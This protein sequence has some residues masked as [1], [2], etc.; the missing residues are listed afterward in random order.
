[1]S[2]E[3]V[4][5]MRRHGRDAKIIDGDGRFWQDFGDKLD[6]K[7]E[8]WF[9]DT[10]D[11]GDVGISEGCGSMLNR[12]VGADCK[13]SRDTVDNLTSMMFMQVAMEG[14]GRWHQAPQCARSCSLH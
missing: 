4:Q 10:M 13:S 1:M 12:R 8:S 9:A 3:R 11:E 5:S 7:I 14:L 2:I 6:N